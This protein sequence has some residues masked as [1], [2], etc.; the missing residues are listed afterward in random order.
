MRCRPLNS[1]SRPGVAPPSNLFNN[2]NNNKPRLNP[3][4]VLYAA[5][6]SSRIN[7]PLKCFKNSVVHL[8]HIR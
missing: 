1:A 7:P 2:F 5:D 6:S 8:V 3:R 4:T